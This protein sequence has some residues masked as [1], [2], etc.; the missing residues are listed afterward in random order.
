MCV[1]VEATSTRKGVC[2][3]E[4]GEN[5]RVPILVQKVMMITA[6]LIDFIVREE[7]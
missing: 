3:E 4:V 5:A 7:N 2:L 1:H 6:C